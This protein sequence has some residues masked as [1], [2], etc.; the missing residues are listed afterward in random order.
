MGPKWI[1]PV[2]CLLSGLPAGGRAGR[3]HLPRGDRAAARALPGEALA[4]GGGATGRPAP[5]DV[6]VFAAGE[7]DLDV[8]VR[9]GSLSRELFACLGAF[10]IHRPPLRERK[11]ES[12]GPRTAGYSVVS[13]EAGLV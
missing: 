6:W 8:E 2:G 10:S 1:A 13:G 7:G 11:T 3:E 9:G 4:G 12:P 5:A